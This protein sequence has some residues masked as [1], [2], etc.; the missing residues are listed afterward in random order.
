MELSCVDVCKGLGD[1]KE[2]RIGVGVWMGM[3]I[4]EG[5]VSDFEICW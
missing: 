4:T 3:D 2:D 1:W 5:N